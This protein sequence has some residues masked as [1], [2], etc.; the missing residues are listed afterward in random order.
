MTGTPWGNSINT[1]E[2]IDIVGLR[3][4]AVNRTVA[5]W[6]PDSGLGAAIVRGSELAEP[7]VDG[8]GLDK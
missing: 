8:I 2:K 7:R 1:V 5:A 3:H 6:G 4:A